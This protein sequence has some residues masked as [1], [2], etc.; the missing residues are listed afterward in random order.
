MTYLEQT[1]FVTPHSSYFH[2]SPRRR[3]CQSYSLKSQPAVF[4]ARRRCRQSYL[5][6]GG[7]A[8]FFGELQ[9]SRTEAM[10]YG[11]NVKNF[12]V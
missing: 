4:E 6:H 2:S 3:R 8:I 9:F 12:S 10:K 11:I 5:H 1:T 7:H